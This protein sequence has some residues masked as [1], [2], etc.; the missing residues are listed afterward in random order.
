M[1]SV[2]LTCRINFRWLLIWRLRSSK[3]LDCVL[4]EL[5]ALYDVDTLN[6]MYE[7][8]IGDADYSL[9]LDMIQ[10]RKQDMFWIRFEKRLI[11]K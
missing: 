8:A 5:T 1:T 4:H 10:R 11:V 7:M 6:Q 9:Y 2:S 3:E